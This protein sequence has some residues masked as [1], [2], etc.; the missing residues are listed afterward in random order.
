[1]RALWIEIFVV[2]A[3]THCRRKS[4]PVRALWIEMAHGLTMCGLNLSR[5]VRAL[6]IEISERASSYP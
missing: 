3:N 5:P 6:W 2:P 4:R 1:M